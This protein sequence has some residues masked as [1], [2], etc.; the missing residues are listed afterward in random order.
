MAGVAL[1]PY[2]ADMTE[3]VNT[4]EREIRGEGGKRT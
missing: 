3:K 2:W 4:T 1:L